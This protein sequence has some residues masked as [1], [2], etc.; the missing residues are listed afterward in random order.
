MAYGP[1]LAGMDQLL[2]GMVV[3]VLNGTRA[4]D[5]PIEQPTRFEFVINLATARALGLSIPQTLLLRADEVI[6]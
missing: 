3:R 1:S 2:S 5:L 6:E 4:G